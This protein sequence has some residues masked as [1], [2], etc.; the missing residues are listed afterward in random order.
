[1]VKK[2]TWALSALFVV[3]FIFAVAL[4]SVGATVHNQRVH[5]HFQLRQTNCTIHSPAQVV[6]ICNQF[7]AAWN[8]GAI[9]EDV[10][11]AKD[12]H[13]LAQD[14]TGNYRVGRTYPCLCHTITSHSNETL[15]SLYHASYC[16]L[17]LESTRAVLQTQMIYKYGSD[18]M[19]SIGC[20]IFLSMV[21]II[22]ILLYKSRKA[23]DFV[24][25][26]EPQ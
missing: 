14:M 6:P 9:V 21:M 3:L 13:E 16:Y 26:M 17:N 2:R 15:C 11:A 23:N 25:M 10:Y 1:M 18:A 24:I 8:D 19:I 5:Q 22:A 12:T 4:I 20:L 7:V